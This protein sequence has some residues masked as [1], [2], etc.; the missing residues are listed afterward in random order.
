MLERWKHQ[1]PVATNEERPILTVDEA[2]KQFPNQWILMAVSEFDRDNL[3]VRGQII[4]NKG[5]NVGICRALR[6]VCPDSN[7]L[8]QNSYYIFMGHDRAHTGEELTSVLKEAAQKGAV[9]AWRR[10]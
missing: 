6:K 2:A 10:W 7:L 3:P 9:G 5:T 8:L 4:A 1:T